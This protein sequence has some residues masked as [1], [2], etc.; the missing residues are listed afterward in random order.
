MSISLSVVDA[1][2]IYQ[3]TSS[4]LE[5]T[6]CVLKND[7]HADHTIIMLCDYVSLLFSLKEI[8][9]AYA[10]YINEEGHNKGVAKN[11]FKT[12]KH[13]AAHCDEAENE[14]LYHNISFQLH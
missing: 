12:L 1:I 9:F 14:F 11:M 6:L 13:V 7:N 5:R 4:T 3:I 10:K 8:T 2:K